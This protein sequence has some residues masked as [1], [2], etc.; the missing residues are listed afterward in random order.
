MGRGLGFRCDDVGGA[1]EDG[2]G[3]A[4]DVVWLEVG[5]LEG[6]GIES[7]ARQCSGERFFFILSN[8]L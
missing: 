8:K 6:M 3:G 4:S 5:F 1:V 2:G 7:K